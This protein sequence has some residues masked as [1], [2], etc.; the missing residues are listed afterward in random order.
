M[1]RSHG[2]YP[3]TVLPVATTLSVLENLTT[4]QY[5]SGNVVDVG[6]ARDTLSALGIVDLVDER[7]SRLSRGQIQR[8]AI[9]RAVVN[10]PKIL[11]AD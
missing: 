8:A 3:A 10:R 5:L 4:A 6:A 1:A 9:A 11:L 2:R 7:P